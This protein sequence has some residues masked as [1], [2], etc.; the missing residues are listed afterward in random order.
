LKKSILFIAPISGFHGQ[1]K[2]SKLVY[3]ELK[4]KYNITLINTFS[5]SNFFIKFLKNINIFLKILSYRSSSF[6][7]IY[8]TPSRNL[9]SSFRDFLVLFF[10]GSNNKI[11]AHL[12]GSDFFDFLNQKGFYY[13]KLNKLYLKY[14]H[15]L[16][17]LS[18]SHKIY[19]LGESFSKYVVISNPCELNFSNYIKENNF[20]FSTISNPIKEK[21]LDE[22]LKKIYSLKLNK[23]WTLN[24]I[25]WNK[26]DYKNLYGD[27]LSL[28]DENGSINFLGR[29]D[30]EKKYEVL[31]K[32]NFFIFISRYKSEAQPLVILEA[33][34]C[35]CNIL[36]NKFKMLDD[37]KIYKNVYF[38]DEI[39]N[40]SKIFK[41]FDINNYD[42]NYYNKIKKKLSNKEFIKNIE[43]VII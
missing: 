15:K 1:G 20:I 43:N 7:C 32:S 28:K 9:F 21:G 27:N 38:V 24:V 13:K 5:E 17:I 4:N 14:I 11:I 22:I 26:N 29:L 3:S 42:I 25:G 16:I 31:L 18:E 37:F 8:I 39:N 40:K 2:I 30:G 36:I 19:A 12:H 35:K 34:L 6:D 10:F 41:N 23:K 33:M